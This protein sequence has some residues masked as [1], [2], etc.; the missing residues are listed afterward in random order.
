MHGYLI[1]RIVRTNANNK[2]LIDRCFEKRLHK[3]FP[4]CPKSWMVLI[5][6][7]SSHRRQSH[8]INSLHDYH[9]PKPNIHNTY[10]VLL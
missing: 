5:D 10:C 2:F 4:S 6:P 1:N 7:F 8:V 3:V 9:D